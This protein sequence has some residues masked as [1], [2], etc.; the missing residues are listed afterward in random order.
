MCGGSGFLHTSIPVNIAYPRIPDRHAGSVL[1]AKIRRIP[2]LRAMRKILCV[3]CALPLFLGAQPISDTTTY[4][5]KPL[6]DGLLVG[7]GL[8]ATFVGFSGQSLKDEIPV[9]TVLALDPMDVNAFDRGAL[10]IDLSERQGALRR[11][12]NILFSALAAPLFLALDKRV[13]RQWF[14]VLSL[15]VEASLL[16]SGVQTNVAV[17]SGR[18]RPITYVA[19]ASMEDRQ[20]PVN[21]LSFFSGHTSSTATSCFFMAKV[22]DDMHPELGAKRWLIYG[23]AAVPSALV[24]YSRV[25]GG[26]HF[27]S[28]VIVGSLFG[29]AVGVLVPEFHRRRSA[30]G[31]T[32]VPYSTSDALGLSARWMW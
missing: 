17:I 24:G 32:L 26:K 2:V 9:A 8:L 15:Y 4:H 28:D 31:M 19:E 11:S 12:D 25:Q 16:N 14:P 10:E 6:T 23:A 30:N 1:A 7:G 27:P 3:M 13:R 18:Y 22:L 5:L 20:D 21:H 29:A